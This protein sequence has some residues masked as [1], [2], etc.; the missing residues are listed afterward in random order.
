MGCGYAPVPWNREWRGGTSNPKSQEVL[1]LKMSCYLLWLWGCN[2]EPWKFK[3][4]LVISPVPQTG[5]HRRFTGDFVGHFCHGS[6]RSPLQRHR[7]F[8]AVFGQMLSYSL[9]FVISG[10]FRLLSP[11]AEFVWCTSWVMVNQI[12]SKV[13]NEWS[14]WMKM[15]IWMDMR[16]S[17]LGIC[18]SGNVAMDI[19]HR[20]NEIPTWRSCVRCSRR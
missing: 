13:S 15:R 8:S 10:H 3:G 6:P 2:L 19:S 11:R 12:E 7:K 9:A 16:C 5:V 20:F 18:A 4:I 1:L 14:I 17:S